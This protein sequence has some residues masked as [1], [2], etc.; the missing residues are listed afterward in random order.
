MAVRARHPRRPVVRARRARPC[1]ES[2]EDRT[3]LDSALFTNALSLDPNSLVSGN[4]AQGGDTAFY[5][6]TLTD[7]HY[8]ST[9]LHAADPS[10]LHARLTWLW[11]D[12]RVLVQS[13]GQSATNPDP[14]IAQFLAPGTY[15]VAVQ[16]VTGAGAYTLT[17][18]SSVGGISF[19]DQATFTGFSTARIVRGDFTGDGIPELVVASSGYDSSDGY[20]KGTV[21]VYPRSEVARGEPLFSWS[22][23]VTDINN[24]SVDPQFNALVPADL[25]RDGKLDLVVGSA[26]AGGA[27]VLLGRGDGTFEDARQ[28]Q[29]GTAVWDV[30]VGDFNGDGILDLA[31]ALSQAG[32]VAILPGRGDGSFGSPFF[33]SVGGAQPEALVAADLNHDGRLDLAT[34]DDTLDQ[35]GRPVESSVSVLLGK[36]NGTFQPAGEPFPVGLS[37]G[38]M[39]A[40]DVN[41]DGHIDV[42]TGTS[43]GAVS[44][45][46]GRGDGTFQAETRIPVEAGAFILEVHLVDF[47]Q[48]GRLDLLTADSLNNITIQRGH[49]DG[50]FAADA[51]LVWFPGPKSFVVGDFNGDGANDLYAATGELGSTYFKINRG[52]G[53][54][55]DERPSQ[56]LGFDSF[57]TGNPSGFDQ[58]VTGDFNNDGYLCTGSA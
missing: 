20:D 21:V 43:E 34:V 58:N 52:D 46:L 3:L 12:A 57:Q 49:G 9:T 1:L 7:D 13:D 53:T 55:P 41:G 23:V 8:V 35:G 45:L 27:I 33:F 28:I 36:G 16:D 15:Y 47:D 24:E 51:Q 11:P 37:T 2:L 26:G 4:L 42:V 39:S 31:T 38:S 54:F 25:N 32:Q 10:Q 19:D 50:T 44:L 40:A 18:D 29:L 5:R 6:L 22:L 48:D 30:A 17:T 56:T 14:Q